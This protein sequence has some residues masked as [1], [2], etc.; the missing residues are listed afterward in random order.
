MQN[1]HTIAAA[2][3]AIGFLAP[4][5]ACCLGPMLGGESMSDPARAVHAVALIL[6]ITVSVLWSLWMAWTVERR[7]G[8]SLAALLCLLLCPVGLGWT[9]PAFLD[10]RRP[11]P[12]TP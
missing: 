10:Q 8:R 12:P 6:A 2:S 9:V 7:T 1:G 11:P 4:G 3:L 5:V